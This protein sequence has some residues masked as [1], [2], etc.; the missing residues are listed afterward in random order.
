MAE[1][2][3][4]LQP[5]ACYHIYNHAVGHENFFA[6]DKHYVYFISKFKQHILPIAEVFAYCLMQ[7]HFHL[8]VRIKSESELIKV[9]I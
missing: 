9:L 2:R 4:T 5:E 3:I 8:I 1:P 7:N 6:H